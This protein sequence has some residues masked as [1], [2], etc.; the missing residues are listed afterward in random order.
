MGAAR[1]LPH[2]RAF[3]P[4]RRC[5]AACAPRRGSRS[6]S[7]SVP[8]R[9]PPDS[10]CCR[11]EESRSVDLSISPLQPAR[12]REPG[13]WE[14]GR[15]GDSGVLPLLRSC[16]SWQQAARVSFPQSSESSRLLGLPPTLARPAEAAALWEAEARSPGPGGLCPTEAHGGA[17]FPHSLGGPIYLLHGVS[18]A[19]ADPGLPG[20]EQ[21]RSPV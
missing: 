16:V 5:R 3:E 6:C 1:S 10:C 17:S 19:N 14:P 11:P 20:E 15:E 2:S 8:G 21:D 13:G 9:P 12:R 7:T 4:R 18:P